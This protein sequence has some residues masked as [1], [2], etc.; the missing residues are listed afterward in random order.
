MD[1]CFSA[2]V[3]DM[4]HSQIGTQ[5]YVLRVKFILKLN[6]YSHLRRKN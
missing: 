5:G 4:E 6:M 3:T 1:I 2:S